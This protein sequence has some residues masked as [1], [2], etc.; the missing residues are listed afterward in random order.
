MSAEI[1]ALHA[2]AAALLEARG[3]RRLSE[4]VRAGRV[5]IVGPGELWSM[6]AREVTALRVALAVDA[7]AFV[8]LGDDAALRAVRAAFADAMRSPLT[9]LADLHVELSLPALDQAWR[10]AYRAAPSRPIPAERAAPEAILAG[11]AA[12]L[13]AL[14][15][16]QAAAMLARASLDM[17]P[18]SDATTP[19][20]R[21]VLR[22][23]PRDRARTWEHPDLEDKLRR[24]VHDAASRASEEVSVEVA[25]EPSS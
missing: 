20:L 23:T 6:G 16:A 5:E 25:A 21:C 9:E 2:G 24:A 13:E 11:A 15:E 7:A 18:V 10:H 1:A 8:A 19:L 14:G 4:L 22:L 17:A 3:A 12:L